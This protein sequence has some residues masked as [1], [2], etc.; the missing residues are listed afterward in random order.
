MKCVGRSV[1]V[2]HCTVLHRNVYMHWGPSATCLS[3]KV[4]YLRACYNG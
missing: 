1:T 2:L 3:F 4:E